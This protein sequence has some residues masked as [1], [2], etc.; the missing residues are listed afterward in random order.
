MAGTKITQLRA[1]GAFSGQRYEGLFSVHPVS[2]ITQCRAYGTTSGRRFGSFAGKGAL[3]PPVLPP[4][5]F[6]AGGGG[7][8]G[9]G[10]FYDS[11]GIQEAVRRIRKDTNKHPRKTFPGL[12]AKTFQDVSVAEEER[13]T[14][15]APARYFVLHEK[16]RVFIFHEKPQIVERIVEREVLVPGPTQYIQVGPSLWKVAGVTAVVVIVGLLVYHYIVRKD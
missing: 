13:E 7:G 14:K 12:Y 5:N 4:L 16:P 1:H 2:K 15:T 11:V 3:V 8:G 9:V 10:G 6:G